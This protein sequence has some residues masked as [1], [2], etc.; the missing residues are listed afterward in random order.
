MT[1]AA[2]RNWAQQA[3]KLA[4]YNVLFFLLNSKEISNLMPYVYSSC[5]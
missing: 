1:F 3:A 5:I 4:K 2:P